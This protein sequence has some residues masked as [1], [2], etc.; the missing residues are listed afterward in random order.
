MKIVIITVCFLFALSGYGQ[1]LQ[2]AVVG[3]GGKT[4]SNGTVKLSVSVGEA[5]VGT[6]TNGTFTITQGFEQSENTVTGVKEQTT[7]IVYKLYPNPTTAMITLELTNNDFDSNLNLQIIAI[8][9]KVLT[10]KKLSVIKNATNTCHINTSAYANGNYF[11]NIYDNIG[12]VVKQI[13][14]VK[15]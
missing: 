14:F 5:I 10:T 2:R 1:T 8:D 11:I 4:M 7:K 15:N 9:G 13:K 12:K 3:S 6:K